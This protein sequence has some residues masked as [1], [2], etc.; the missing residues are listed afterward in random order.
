MLASGRLVLLLISAKHFK[1][2]KL[3]ETKRYIFRIAFPI[4]AVSR[5]KKKFHVQVEAGDE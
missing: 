1:N 2:P 4:N 5:K 3:A